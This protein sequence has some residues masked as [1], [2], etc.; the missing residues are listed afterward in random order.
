MA[1]WTS[2]FFNHYPIAAVSGKY[3][4]SQCFHLEIN[5]EELLTLI[6]IVKEKIDGRLVTIVGTDQRIQ[7]KDF[8]IYYVFA[9]DKDSEHFVISYSVSEKESSFPSISTYLPAANW[10]EREIQ[11]LFGLSAENHP[12]PSPLVLHGFHLN[13]GYP[14]RKDTPRDA[15]IVYNHQ[16]LKLTKY[17]SDEIVQIPVGPIHAGIIEPGHFRFGAIGESV[18]HLDA[19]LFYT[20]RGIEKSS[21]GLN[22]EEALQLAERICGVD[23]VSHALSFAQAIE[24]IGGIAVPKRAQYLRSIYLELERIY[25]HVG[26]VGNL[27]AGAG[28]AFGVSHG[29]R[30]KEQLLRL[31][32]K[33]LGHRYLRNIIAIGGVKKSLSNHELQQMIKEIG[34][35]LDDFKEMTDIMMQHEIVLNRMKTTGILR[36]DDADALETVGIAARSSGRNLDARR[37]YPHDAYHDT[38]F[39]VILYSEGDVWARAMVRI[40]EIEQSYSILNQFIAKIPEGETIT[41]Y[42]DLPEYEWAIGVTESPRGENVHFMMTGPNN[43]VERYRIRS[44]P[45]MNWPAVPFTVPGNIIPDFPLINKSFELCYACCDR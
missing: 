33:Y 10:F 40:D 17:E 39:K 11:D 19:Q 32:Q 42:H 43:T 38:E 14:L 23:V 21:E 35:I 20:H 44:A 8:V 25:N 13:S 27:G 9:I 7:G 1:E 30:V 18:L 37:D 4:R 16:P 31:N 36:R 22:V 45:Y 6:P 29:S 34:I 24:K 26:D 41:D 28:F 5:K 15:E 2:I 12:D 3:L